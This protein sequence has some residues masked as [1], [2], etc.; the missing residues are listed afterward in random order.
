MQARNKAKPPIAMTF[1][2]RNGDLYRTDAQ[3]LLKAIQD[4]GRTQEDIRARA[5]AGYSYVEKL[6]NGGGIDGWAAS[7]I[8]WVLTP[9]SQSISVGF[10]LV[11]LMPSTQF[12]KGA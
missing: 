6:L 7:H 4:S 10:S 8:E 2:K 12:P 3:D 11:S 9:E 5:G 1:W